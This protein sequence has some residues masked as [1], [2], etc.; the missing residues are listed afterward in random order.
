MDPSPPKPKRKYRPFT[1]Q[2]F[3]VLIVGAVLAWLI[4][5][6]LG[7][8]LNSNS[9]EKYRSEFIESVVHSTNFSQLQSFGLFLPRDDGAW[10]V[11]KSDAGF[12]YG[13]WTLAVDSDGRWFETRD[14]DYAL[15]WG[16][17]HYG[18][19]RRQIEKFQDMLADPAMSPD[20]RQMCE[21][22][23]ADNESELEKLYPYAAQ[24]AATLDD[25]R[26]ALMS[27]GFAEVPGLPRPRLAG[28]TTRPAATFPAS[29]T[30]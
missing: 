22:Q 2:F 29:P 17:Y 23:I 21:G 27:R 19:C 7:S 12:Q 11:I 13:S 4:A 16:V 26:R 18:N 28:V 3:V 30:P 1:R 15:Y 24:H 14:G 10:I 5:P 25:A 20:E 8:L 6:R 9:R